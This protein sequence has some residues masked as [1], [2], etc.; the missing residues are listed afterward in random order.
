MNG[1]SF[2]EEVNTFSACVIGNIFSIKSDVDRYYQEG[3]KALDMQKIL[4]T[5]YRHLQYSDTYLQACKSLYSV[6]SI[7]ANRIEDITE[8]KYEC[9]SDTYKNYMNQAIILCENF[10]TDFLE[11]KN[12]ESLQES[13]QRK[14]IKFNL[15]FNNEPCLTVSSATSRVKIGEPYTIVYTFNRPARIPISIK[16]NGFTIKKIGTPKIDIENK[17]TTYTCQF[18]FLSYD[19]FK[20]PIATIDYFGEI[21]SSPELKVNLKSP[22]K[23]ETPN[24]TKTDNKTTKIWNE[25][26]GLV[27]AIIMFL[28]ATIVLLIDNMLE[29]WLAFGS[30]IAFIISRILSL[31]HSKF[32][33]QACPTETEAI[34]MKTI[35]GC[36]I[37]EF[38]IGFNRKP[39]FKK[40]QISMFAQ[41]VSYVFISVLYLPLIPIGCYSIMTLWS[42]KIYKGSKQGVKFLGMDKMHF[43][44]IIQIY[45]T[46]YSLVLYV[47]MLCWLIYYLISN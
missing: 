2:I 4:L 41:N 16:A 8:Q 24:T 18:V 12:I 7:L 39:D 11:S 46:C 17:E 31:I 9:G 6:I 33:Y 22:K 21:F 29:S 15:I 40:E 35:N 36:G 20:V 19:T 34:S 42:S 45:L 25:Y 43:S 30:S 13:L 38:P 32:P 1:N 5:D 3:C 47:P 23:E 44:E 26:K 10:N 28:L 37:M 27:I 14:R